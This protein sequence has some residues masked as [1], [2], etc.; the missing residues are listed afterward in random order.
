[1][2]DKV[3]IYA[4]ADLEFLD[5]L[6]TSNNPTG[7]VALNSTTETFVMAALSENSQTSVQI[8]MLN[9]QRE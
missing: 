4:L 5:T 6:A 3:H 9:N 8:V 2:S 1:M 7:L